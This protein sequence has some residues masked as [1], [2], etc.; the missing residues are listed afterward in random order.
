MIVSLQSCDTSLSQSVKSG[1]STLCYYDT[2]KPALKYNLGSI[3]LAHH[4]KDMKNCDKKEHIR[5]LSVQ[6]VETNMTEIIADAEPEP[7]SKLSP[8]AGAIYDTCGLSLS[9]PYLYTR[10]A[11]IARDS[12]MTKSPNKKYCKPIDPTKSA[13]ISAYITRLL[14]M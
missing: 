6:F 8:G 7:V 1:V 12:F 2:V 11:A 10:Y 4:I 13:E 14:I 5:P 3:Q 9:L